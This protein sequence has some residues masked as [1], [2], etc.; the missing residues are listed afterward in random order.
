MN[1]G[2]SGMHEAIRKIE[3]AKRTQSTT[4]PKAT[5]A[6]P[7]PKGSNTKELRSLVDRIVRLEEEKR[8][9]GA[10]IKT[11]YAAVKDTGF[12]VKAIRI[13]VR[14]EMEDADQKAAR[15]AVESEVDNI[16]VALGDFVS[17]PLG[18]SAVSRASRR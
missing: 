7:A 2:M 14:R 17:S 4:S 8:G 10:D 5:E 15:E 18:E 1:E 6:E 12:N 11:I 13:I 16:T 9:I 3:E